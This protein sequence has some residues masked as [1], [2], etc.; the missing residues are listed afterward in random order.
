MI[1]EQVEG[2]ISNAICFLTEDS[3]AARSI[4][5]RDLE[6]KDDIMG[7]HTHTQNATKG[8]K[9]IQEVTQTTQQVV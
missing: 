4:E 7:Q 9:L 5:R 1:S 2:K 3:A 6:G 8:L